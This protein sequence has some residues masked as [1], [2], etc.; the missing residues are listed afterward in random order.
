M[1]V[2]MSSLTTP[3]GTL[4]GQNQVNAERPAAGRHVGQA[5][6]EIRHLLDQEAELVH[7]QHQ[8]GQRTERFSGRLIVLDV[9]APGL[10]QQAFPVPDLSGQG[11]QRA[12]REVLVQVG[13]EPH[14]MRQGRARRERR[15]ALEVDQHE[16]EGFGGIAE[17]ERGDQR[18]QELAL[19]RPG[20]ARY[21]HVRPVAR[22][23]QYE[24]AGGGAPERYCGDPRAT[25]PS[26]R[27]LLG[28]GPVHSPQVQQA[29]GARHRGPLVTGGVADGRERPGH[30]VG[31][32]GVDDVQLRDLDLP[33][34]VP[35][36][37]AAA[38]R[39]APSPAQAGPHPARLSLAMGRP[40]P[41]RAGLAGGGTRSSAG[42][43][44]LRPGSAHNT[45]LRTCSDRVRAAGPATRSRPRAG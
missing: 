35:V 7:D 3:G 39:T 21:Q 32:L 18:L 10:E 11:H 5:L 15:P 23:I 30:P 36:T 26:G 8:P 9:L 13:Q 20:G 6:Q 22:D 42:P 12:L 43:I 16:D 45:G 27:D 34:P 24:R 31:P 38:H 33:L 28:G 29:D 44:R 1:L 19:A 2:R 17:R 41:H 14:D 40:G 37:G 25:L 4:R